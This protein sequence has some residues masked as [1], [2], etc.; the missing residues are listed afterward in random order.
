MEGAH[1]RAYDPAAGAIAKAELTHTEIVPDAQTAIE[2]ADALVVLTEWPEFRD[3][4]LEHVRDSLRRPVIVDGRNLWPIERLAELGFTY[5]S[6]GR[7]D[8]TAG[9]IRKP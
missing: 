9:E 4:D 6:F 2:G 5:Y 3:A 7:P 1:V 8:V